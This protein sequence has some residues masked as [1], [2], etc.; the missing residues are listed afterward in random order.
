M[1]GCLSI[2]AVIATAVGAGLGKYSFWWVL[3][4]VFFAGSFSLSNGPGYHLVM[5][6]NREG[7]LGLFPRMLAFHI[8]VQ[9]AVAGALFWV[10]NALSS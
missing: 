9:L 1:L 2:L 4:P 8:V 3:V 7:R 6:A 5:Q 10:T